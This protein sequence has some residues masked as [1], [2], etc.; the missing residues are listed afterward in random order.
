MSYSNTELINGLQTGFV[1]QHIVSQNDFVPKLLL[2][3][4]LEGKK[5]LSSIINELNTCNEFW[6]P[7][8]LLLLLESLH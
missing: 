5:I 8:H 4:K 2:N 3:D 1:D 7:L 6:F